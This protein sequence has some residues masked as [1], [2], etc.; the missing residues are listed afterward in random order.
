MQGV[1]FDLDGT[2]V[3]TIPDIATA[4]NAAVVDEGLAP[5]SIDQVKSVVGRGL[6]N[7]LKDGLDIRGR[8][9]PDQRLDELLTKLMKTYTE[10]PV[11]YS[12]PYAGIEDFLL[13]LVDD[14]IAVGV[15]SNK[16]DSLI[17]VI[18]SDLFPAIPFAMVEGMRSDRPRKPDPQGI[19]A[20]ARR[21]GAPLSRI[22]Y[23]GDSEV[24]W[25]TSRNVP[26][27]QVAI[28]TWGFRSKE[29]LQAGGVCSLIDTIGELEE[30]IWR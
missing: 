14:G 7:A 21:I 15:L 20:F 2:L 24:D 5:L 28:V 6:R 11:D 22:L 3:D 17:Q 13:R 23:V 25:Q 18:V 10:H 12:R 26:E 9:V 19:L 16:A 4:L 27:A 1:L 30:R 8:E 29:I